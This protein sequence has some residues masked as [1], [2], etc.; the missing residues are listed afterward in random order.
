M[1][2]DLEEILKERLPTKSKRKVDSEIEP[3]TRK[4]IDAQYSTHAVCHLFEGYGRKSEE[5]SYLY[6]S[7]LLGIAEELVNA[8]LLP[9]IKYSDFS[10][11]DRIIEPIIAYNLDHLEE[12]KEGFAFK[13]S[14]LT[15][16]E[17][18]AAYGKYLKAN[19][20]GEWAKKGLHGYLLEFCES[21]SMSEFFAKYTDGLRKAENIDTPIE[22]KEVVPGVF[23]DVDGTL[24]KSIYSNGKSDPVKINPTY[25]YVL[26]KL[27]EGIPVT[28]FTGG[29]LDEALG[30][31]RAA[32]VDERLCDVKSKTGYINRTLEKCIDDTSPTRQGF[33]AKTH[34]E[35]GEEAWNAEYPTIALPEAKPEIKIEEKPVLI[36]SATPSISESKVN[37][38]PVELTGQEIT[39]KRSFW[40]RLFRR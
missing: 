17:F 37:E 26:K 2:N 1:T 22:E 33:R 30:K 20:S 18:I 28:V 29:R 32:K 36:A 7:N 31:L 34:Y 16:A 10:C 19:P 24:I 40:Y 35:S 39:P 14:I 23:V 5:G 13:P 6:S 15:N 27:E 9:T 25:Q 3:L 38:Q 21:K 8:T 12:N 4:F 11:V